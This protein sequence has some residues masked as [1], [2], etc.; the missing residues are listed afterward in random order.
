MR[1]ISITKQPCHAQ[2]DEIRSI[3]VHRRRHSMAQ[4]K[5]ITT[6]NTRAATHK[7]KN[8]PLYPLTLPDYERAELANAHTRLFNQLVHQTAHKHTHS[9]AS[10]HTPN[11]LALA[12]RQHNTI[13]IVR[14]A[15]FCWRIVYSEFFPHVFS[16]RSTRL[17]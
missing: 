11:I 6:T 16:W 13:A 3:L 2:C 4:G 12:F 15:S 8:T 9:V 7:Q 5:N 17:R 14:T 1:Q 10:I